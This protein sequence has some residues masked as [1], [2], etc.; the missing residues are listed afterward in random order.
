M[1]KHYPLRFDPKLGNGVCEICR[2]PCA[3]VACT[4]MLDKPWIYG[5][6]SDKQ[7]RYKYAT[8]STYWIV[9]GSFNNCNIIQLS[10]KSTPSDVFD[11]I[12]QVVLDG[13]SDNMALLVESLNH[14]DINTNDT[15]TNGFYVIIFTSEAYTLQENKRIV[16]QGITAEKFFVNAQYLCFMQVD[17]NWYCNQHLQ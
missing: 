2:I 13:I 8:K 16:G 6:P 1:S 17:N 5:I 4:S 3:C 15:S 14:G 9:L 12:H 11:E 10:Q 7:E